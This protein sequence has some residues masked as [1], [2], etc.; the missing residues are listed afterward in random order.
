M[1]GKNINILFLGGAKRVSIARMLV[2]AGTVYDCKVNIFSYELDKHVPISIVGNVILGLKWNDAK[3]MEHLH[4]VVVEHG[5]DI[6]IPFVDAAVGVVAHYRSIYHDV[7]APVC[8]YEK[9]EKMFDKVAS[10]QEFEHAGLN[11]PRTYRTGRPVFPLIAKPRH[12]S[13]SRGIEILEDV[14][15]FRRI[16][17][18]SDDY[19][20][21]KYVR[22]RKEYTVD[23][24]VTANGV[25]QCV[26]PRLRKEVIGGEVSNTVTVADAEID[27]AARKTISRLGLYGAITIQFLR[28]LDTDNLLLMEIN[29]RLGGGVVCSVHAGAPIPEYIIGEYLKTPL[30][31]SEDWKEG[32]E[33]V[34]Y[35]QEVVFENGTK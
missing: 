10:A 9:V 7:W 12:G 33:I 34:R 6:M 16:I 26:V 24:Y 30:T 31:P 13:A 25:V 4:E 23:C 19:L 21:Q 14:R 20:I 29:P 27:D 2:S 17:A 5:I 28:D 35:M 1:S 8:S 11:I 32:V 15:E 3:L 18:K 22:N